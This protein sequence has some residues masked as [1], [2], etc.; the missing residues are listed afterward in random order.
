MKGPVVSG[1]GV[2]VRGVAPGFGPFEQRTEFIAGS[3][4]ARN[5]QQFTRLVNRL[6]QLSEAT[7]IL[8][9]RKGWDSNPPFDPDS[10]I[11]HYT[12]MHCKPMPL[13][14]Y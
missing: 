4:A 5:T 14:A 11:H 6:N 12:Q 2:S 7:H 8:N 9:W 3:N 1:P 10:T 13:L